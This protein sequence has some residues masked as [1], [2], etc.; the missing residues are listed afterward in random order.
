MTSWYFVNIKNGQNAAYNTISNNEE[1]IIKYFNFSNS[2]IALND[3]T[4]TENNIS[5][6]I[7]LISTDKLDYN[8][9]EQDNSISNKVSKNTQTYKYFYEKNKIITNILVDFY[10]KTYE[11]RAEECSL[12]CE[13]LDSKE[14]TD[15]YTK[16]FENIKN[17]DLF[18]D[19]SSLK[20]IYKVTPKYIVSEYVNKEYKKRVLKNQNF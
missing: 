16:F 13:W 18:N 7:N 4:I 6:L 11:C 2:D 10:S 9:I 15:I 12:F 1:K 8:I 17:N 20:K 14:K 3:K 19:F 5:A